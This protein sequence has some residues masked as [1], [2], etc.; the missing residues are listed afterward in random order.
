MHR[1]WALCLL[2]LLAIL[3]LGGLLASRPRELV[4]GVWTV[5]TPGGCALDYHT[6]AKALALACPGVDYVRLW[7]LPVEQ[8]WE[9]P[10]RAPERGPV[11]KMAGPMTLYSEMRY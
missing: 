8:P 10:E 7:P 1:R 3:L 4:E 11:E 9:E 5:D 2:A 6:S